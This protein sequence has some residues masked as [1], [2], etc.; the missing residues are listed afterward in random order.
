V[1]EGCAEG[2]GTEEAAA[3]EEGGGGGG[4]GGAEGGRVGREKG[5]WFVRPPQVPGMPL[6]LPPPPLLLP[7]PLL[8]LLPPR[9]PKEGGSLKALGL[10]RREDKPLLPVMEGMPG[11]PA[12]A[13]PV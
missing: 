3:E 7:L 6:L 2:G 11:P 1:V 4:R 13:G 12:K 9:P 10:E 5:L 8:L